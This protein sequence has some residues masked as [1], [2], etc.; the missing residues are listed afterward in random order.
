LF[1]ALASYDPNDPAFSV[2]GDSQTVVN[3]MG[4]A[5]AWFADVAFLLFGQPAYLFPVLVLL[6]GILFYR[7]RDAQQ[8]ATGKATIW[9]SVGFFLTLVTSCG[10]ATLHF[11]AA[12]LR[13]TAG[14]VI[15]QLVGDGSAYV[16]SPL[17]ATVFLLVLWL[18]AVSL[19]T[20]ISWLAVM[21]RV[22]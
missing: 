19:A 11:S 18:A 3:L 1:F 14:G 9:R 8:T 12:S 13:E 20:G 21:D 16:L 22:G 15:G 10:L 7:A 4:R 6:G 2:S 5:G 17:G